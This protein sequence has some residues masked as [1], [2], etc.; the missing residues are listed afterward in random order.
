MDSGLSW[1][2][3]PLFLVHPRLC[4]PADSCCFR[5]CIK[6]TISEPDP[7]DFEGHSRGVK[8]FS[9]ADE[10]SRRKHSLTASAVHETVPIAQQDIV[11]MCFLFAQPM[12]F[13]LTLTQLF[14]STLASVLTCPVPAFDY[15]PFSAPHPSKPRTYSPNSLQPT[16]SAMVALS[17]LLRLRYLAYIPRS[18]E[19]FRR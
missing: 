6:A 18:P 19:I 12:Y 1:A 7:R 15:S 9:R 4:D 17:T 16:F 13:L 14:S 3:Q 10:L 11:N 5:K 2:L 8:G